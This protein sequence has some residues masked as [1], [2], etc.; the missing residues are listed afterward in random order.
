MCVNSDKMF[1]YY[2]EIIDTPF[3]D[4]DEAVREYIK[5]YIEYLESE[6]ERAKKA[7]D[8]EVKRANDK[9]QFMKEFI[10]SLENL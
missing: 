7:Y 9:T 5:K 3:N 4:S 6:V 1:A 2:Q 10:E 8:E